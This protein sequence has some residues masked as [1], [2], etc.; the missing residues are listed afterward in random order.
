MQPLRVGYLHF[1]TGGKMSKTQRL[2]DLINEIRVRPGQTGKQ[3]SEKFGCTERTILRDFDYLKST[4]KIIVTNQDGYRFYSEPYFHPLGLN[5]DEIMAL[6]L[7]QNLAESH[8]DSVAVKALANAI[9]K[10]FYSTPETNKRAA[11]R[12][13]QNTASITSPTIEA[14]LASAV[15]SDLRKAAIER[16]EIKFL[17]RGRSDDEYNLRHVEPVGVYIQEGRWYLRAF[18]LDKQD[19]RTFRPSRMSE[20]EV[21]DKYFEPRVVF[22]ADQAA[23]HQWDLCE[24]D[25]TTLKIKVSPSLAR[26]F[27]ENKPHPSVAVEKTTVTI[28]VRDP[29]SFLL[30]FAK[31]DDAELIGPPKYRDWL[32]KRFSKL[33][34]IYSR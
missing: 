20:L 9:N 31:L 10:I 24:G 17:Y 27:N 28:S 23:F 30:W 7:A 1:F 3:L 14:D 4:L 18:D 2:F 33:Q 6:A 13:E 32:Y 21:A 19:V 15:L 11:K 16:R 22:S 5:Q 8:L 34:N 12:V 26:W 29:E 25:P